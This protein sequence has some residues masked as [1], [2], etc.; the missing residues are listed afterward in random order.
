M[1]LREQLHVHRR[2]G[3]VRLAG[4]PE[5]P[6][7]DPRTGIAW[8]RICP[9][10][11]TM[12]TVEKDGERAVQ[13]AYTDEMSKN[14]RSAPPRIVI[15]SAYALAATETTEEQCVKIDPGQRQKC[16]AGNTRPVV[17]IAWNEARTICQQAGGDLPTEAQ[18]EYAARGGSRL[19]W[20]FGD[21][22]G[23]LKYYA[24]YGGNAREIQEA[25]RRRPNSLGL[26]D[27]HGNVYEWVRDWYGEYVSGV[28]VDP[29]GPASGKCAQF[30]FEKKTVQFDDSRA[31][32]VV[33]GGSFDG[34]P[35]RL[36][37]AVRVGDLP[38]DWD[39]NLGFR[40]VRVPPP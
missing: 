1:E 6:Q 3:D 8:V 17:N 21:D 12:G 2:Q 4:G 18:W 19:L 5:E 36:R 28:E 26:Y 22:E 40:C 14:E 31:C 25:G 11:F 7:T 34:P 15:L 9:G 38:E 13:M 27:M 24:W 30:D 37:S 16:A 10:T 39:L 29:T 20:S 33:R 35:V 32:W 23:L